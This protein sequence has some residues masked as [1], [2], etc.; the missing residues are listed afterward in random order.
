MLRLPHNNLHGVLS[1][2][3]LNRLSALQWLDLS[4][5]SIAISMDRQGWSLHLKWLD[6]SLTLCSEAALPQSE[7]LWAHGCGGGGSVPTNERKALELLFAA[8]GGERCW[9]RRHGWLS[10]LPEGEWEGITVRDGHVVAISLPD[11]GLCGQLP[12]G[13]ALAALEF[14]SAVNL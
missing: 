5:N 9:Q 2:R 13:F 8:T 14:V 4:G 12:Q 3:V 7:V 11:N 10:S 6:L 1:S